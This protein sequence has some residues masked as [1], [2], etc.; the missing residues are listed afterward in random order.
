MLFIVRNYKRFPLDLHSIG[1]TNFLEYVDSGKMA[2]ILYNTES[3]RVIRA[4][5]TNISPVR[6]C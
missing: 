6:L 3:R 2:G 5:T 4:R 1:P